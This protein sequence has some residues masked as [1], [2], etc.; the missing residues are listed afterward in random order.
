MKKRQF[1]KWRKDL[2]LTQPQ[3]A[4]LLGYERSAIMKWE[5]GINPVP[6]LVGVIHQ[7]VSLLLSNEGK[8]MKRHEKHDEIY[9][10]FKKGRPF[11]EIDRKLGLPNGKARSYL[12]EHKLFE[13]AVCDFR[14]PRKDD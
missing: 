1:K 4:Q 3:L 6:E 5:Q 10:M 11:A 12:I 14:K 9:E 8:P 2:G 13:M 7:L